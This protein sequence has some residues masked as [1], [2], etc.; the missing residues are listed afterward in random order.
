M[1]RT[2][3]RPEEAPADGS[4]ADL[5]ALAQAAEMDAVEEWQE[6]TSPDGDDFEADT[7]AAIFLHE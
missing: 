6:S 3:S 1:L 2:K 5:E 4:S 7:E